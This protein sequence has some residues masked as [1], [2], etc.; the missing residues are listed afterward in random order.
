MLFPK[1]LQN[2]I[3]KHY[4][5]IIHMKKFEII[6]MENYNQDIGFGMIGFLENR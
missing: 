3:L 2:K 5:L 1:H 4:L 6:N